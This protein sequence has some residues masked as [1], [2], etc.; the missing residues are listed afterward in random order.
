[1]NPSLRVNEDVAVVV[2][3]LVDGAID[4]IGT[5]YTPHPLE[6]K[7]CEWQAGVFGMIGLEIALPVVQEVLVDTDR[8]NWQDVAHIISTTPAVTDRV[9]SRGQG[10]VEDKP[11]NLT[12]YNPTVCCTVTSDVQY[13]ITTGTPFLGMELSRQVRYTMWRESLTVRD[14]VAVSLE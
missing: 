11:A 3:G 10:I 14:S 2:K 5:D 7:D 4:C 9:P 13:S 1:M 6:I 12:S 8:M